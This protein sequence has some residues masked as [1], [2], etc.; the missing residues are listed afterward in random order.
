MSVST[1]G[2]ILLRSITPATAALVG[3]LGLACPLI[4][5]TVAHMAVGSPSST[6]G[7]AI[8]VAVV[9]GLFGAAVGASIGFI[10]Q[11]AVN[12]SRWAGPADLRAVAVLLVLGIGIPS[13]VVTRWSLA[14]DAEAAARNEPRVMVSSETVVRIEGPYQLER[15]SPAT[16]IWTGLQEPAAREL[17]WNGDAIRVIVQDDTMAFR[18]GTVTSSPLDLEGFDYVREVHAVPAT[19]QGGNSEWLAVL[20]RLRASGRREIF[21]IFDPQGKLAYQ[22]LFERRTDLDATVLWNA[23]QSPSRQHIL[24]D[25][26][27]PLSFGARE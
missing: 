3:G 5:A 12:R 14:Y 23:G 10:V 24:L 22:E 16:L 9:L 4:F 13:V 7:L 1:L 20:L 25:A 17:R 15:E 19:L 2:V 6:A 21:A 8:P 11:A 18:S 27:K 26:G